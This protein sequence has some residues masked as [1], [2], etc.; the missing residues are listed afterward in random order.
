M[1]KKK[2]DAEPEEMILYECPNCR[3]YGLKSLNE[4]RIDDTWQCLLCQ[5][6]MKL[7]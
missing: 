5:H 7:T 3:F 6:N 4:I 1:S 2:K